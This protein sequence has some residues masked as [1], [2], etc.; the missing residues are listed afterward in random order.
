MNEEVKKRALRMIPYGMDVLTTKSGQ[1]VEVADEAAG[2]RDA[3]LIRRA[4]RE[5]SYR[6][7][8]RPWVGRLGHAGRAGR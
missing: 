3:G 1:G 6:I 2:D 8:R 5:R 4:G 7:R